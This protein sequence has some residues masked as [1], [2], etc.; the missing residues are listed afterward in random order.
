METTQPSFQNEN[1]VESTWKPDPGFHALETTG[2]LSTSGFHAVSMW[3]PIHGNSAIRAVVWYQNCLCSYRIRKKSTNA[4]T[5]NSEYRSQLFYKDEEPGQSECDPSTSSNLGLYKR[6]IKIRNSKESEI[7]GV[8]LEDIFSC[9]K[10]LINGVD[11]YLK[12]YRNNVSFVLLSAEDNRQY[13]IKINDAI[14]K[15]MRVK[16]DP[17]IIIA[18]SKIL[19]NESARYQFLKSE[20]KTHV[21]A[22]D[23][24]LM[25]WDIVWPNATPR[26]I[27]LGLIESSSLNGDLTKNPLYFDH[28]NC[29]E[30]GIYV[31]GE[32]FPHRPFKTDFA[33]KLYSTAFQSLFTVCPSICKSKELVIDDQDFALGYSLYAFSLEPIYF[34]QEHVNLV[35]QANI[36][37]E[38]RFG[39]PLTETVTC[40][41]FAEFNEEI[42]I[43]KTRDVRLIQP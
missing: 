42:T 29:I 37:I 40:V 30:V 3:F 20:V 34:D 24:N 35:K 12:L 23:S 39:T 22:K 27:V 4:G 31:N 11:L 7:E 13:R 15:C 6:A 2:K 9:S 1:P 38:M 41:A 16:V 8:I 10:Y 32:S 5:L 43:D 19:E 18:H 26:I 33:K 28:F 14:L 36:R 17:G 25:V 21:V